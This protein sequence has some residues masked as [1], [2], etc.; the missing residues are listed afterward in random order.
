MIR[1]DLGNSPYHAERNRPASVAPVISSRPRWPMSVADSIVDLVRHAMKQDGRI[2]LVEQA[3]RIT[4]INYRQIWLGEV[5]SGRNGQRIDHPSTW[6]LDG[7]W[8]AA[9]YQ[10]HA[11]EHE[12]LLYQ[13]INN[14]PA[15][16]GRYCLEVEENGRTRRVGI[17]ALLDELED[18]WERAHRAAAGRSSEVR[19]AA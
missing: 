16:N 3:A 14:G 12:G 18:A 1:L 17:A 9:C 11:E 7:L 15:A 6:I 2:E 19:H 13:A 5:R 4:R 10:R 8:S